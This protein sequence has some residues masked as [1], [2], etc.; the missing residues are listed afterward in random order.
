MLKTYL[1]NMICTLYIV[2]ETF[3]FYLSSNISNDS[4]SNPSGVHVLLFHQKSTIFFT[5]QPAYAHCFTIQEA[6][7]N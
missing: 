7:Y 3:Y 5:S 4:N 1:E 2:L 6:K